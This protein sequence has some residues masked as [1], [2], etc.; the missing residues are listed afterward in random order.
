MATRVDF[1]VK[2]LNDRVVRLAKARGIDV[3]VYAP[4][5]TRVT[6]IEARAK[7]YSD[8]DLLVVPAR[9]IF[10]GTWRNRKHVL[11]IG[12]TEPIPDFISLSGAMDALERSA[13]ATLVPH[14]DFLTV[15]LDEDDL[16]RYDG[17]VDALEVYNPKHLSRHNDVARQLVDEIGIPAFGSSYAHLERTVGEV[18]TEFDRTISSTEELL[19]AIVSEADRRV[20]RRTGLGHRTRCALEKGH[21]GYEN[22]WKKIDRLL[23]SGLEPTHPDHIAYDGAFDDVSVY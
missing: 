3:L 10:T 16:K 1:H 17:I 13:G 4:H 12:L 18:W 19:D 9:E 5:F 8:D 11:G 7:R 23:L 21:L 6:T 15:S 20:E 2:V 14:P 22:T